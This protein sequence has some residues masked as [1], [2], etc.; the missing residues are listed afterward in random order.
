MVE[1]DASGFGQFNTAR[2]AAK[3]LN[4][5]FALD[6]LDAL[7]ERRL[8]HA[9][10]FGGPRDMSFFS[11]FCNGDEIPEMSKLHCHIQFN[12]NFATFI[13]YLVFLGSGINLCFGS[14][15][16]PVVPRWRFPT[17]RKAVMKLLRRQFLQLTAG[18]TFAPNLTTAA[19]AQTYPTRPVRVIVPY[20]AAGPT[21]ILARLTA[22]KLSERLGKQFYVENIGGAGGNI[23]MGQG[24]RAAPDGYTVLVVPPN[25]VVN[26]AMY[27]TVPY[28]PYKDFDPVTIAVTSPTVLTV[29][30][31]L[32]VQTVKDLVALIKSGPAKYSFAS[33]GTGTPPHLI[34]EHFR[35]LLGL[36]LVHVP[37]NSAGLAV[38]STLAGH[39][40]IAFTSLP[41]AVS[42]INEGKLRALAVTSKMR[43]QALPEVPSMAEAGY[44]EVEG[45]GWFAFIV[46]ARTPKEITTLLHGEIIKII[47]L[48][49]I[50]EKM[51]T[52]GFEPVGS[53]PD[54]AA[55]L[56]K[57]E[58]AKWAKVIREAGIKAQ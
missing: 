49:D 5:K 51:A 56:F 45:A 33:P 15:D 50:M 3:E 21:D 53:T 41:P 46:P 43:S 4:I 36:D 39:T 32:A 42:Q 35:L 47:A 2:L 11:F 12:M 18:A 34:G 6:R 31:S 55:A 9:E 14:I 28:D 23:G 19:S 30:P 37:F 44:P 40:P 48:P 22:Q 58:G 20:A 52:L 13:L 26:P 1:E 7:A 24:A 57:T 16:A 38:G 25:I 27:D 29:H 10:P 54:E 8:L 17:T